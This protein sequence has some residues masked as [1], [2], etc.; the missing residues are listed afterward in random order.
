MPPVLA[1]SLCTA[2]V[3]YLLWLDQQESPDVSPVSWIPTLWMIYTASKPLGVWFRTA[4]T[5][6]ESGKP[7]GSDIPDPNSMSWV[8]RPG[9]EKFQTAGSRS[10]KQVVDAV[11]LLYACEYCLVRHPLRINEAMDSRADC[12]RYGRCHRDG[13]GSA[14]GGPEHLEEIGLYSDP[15][16]V[17]SDEVVSVLGVQSRRG[18]AG[19]ISWVGVTTQKNGLGRLCLIASF[20]LI[21]SLVSRWRKKD[22]SFFTVHSLVDVTVLLLSFLL[23][24]GPEGAYS[25]SAIVALGVGLAVFTGLVW[26]ERAADVPLQAVTMAFGLVLII[27]FGTVTVFVSGETVGGFTSNLGRDTT[28]TGRTDVWGTLVPVVFRH[29]PGSGFGGF[30]TYRTREVYQISEGHSGYLD[31]LLDLGFVG[32]L[33]VSMFLLTSCVRAGKQLEKDFDWAILWIGYLI[34]AAVHN[35]AESSFDTLTSQLTAVLVFL[36]AASMQDSSDLPA[37]QKRGEAGDVAG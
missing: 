33:L 13:N 26:M 36:A 37:D 35:I 11:A 16:F 22:V 19:A 32:L 8:A 14:P 30:W 3:L 7:T 1:L 25:A 29:L 20:F 15:L 17:A 6:I 4:T 2:F 9:L 10:R 5:D 27:I 28:L 34:M 24:I 18:G 23:L 31:V 12:R 21:W